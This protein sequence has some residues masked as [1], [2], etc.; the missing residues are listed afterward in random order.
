MHLISSATSSRPS[1]RTP[2]PITATLLALLM[3]GLLTAGCGQPV[4]KTALGPA[5][6]AVTTSDAAGD[7]S[8]ADA[9]GSDA[10]SADAGGGWHVGPDAGVAFTGGGW[11]KVKNE[12]G[13]IF[14]FDSRAVAL[15]LSQTKEPEIGKAYVWWMRTPGH[16]VANFGVLE[17]EEK[18]YNPDISMVQK[19][20]VANS[21]A[22]IANFNGAF[23]TYEDD[24]DLEKL[25]A[26]V[27]PVVW[28]GEIP[29]LA[30]NHVQHVLTVS[31]A[32]AQ[33]PGYIQMAGA[34]MTAVR[35]QLKAAE[36]AIK[37]GKPLVAVMHVENIHTLLVGVAEAKDLTGDKKFKSDLSVYTMG[38]AAGDT[39]LNEALKHAGFALKAAEGSFT[40]GIKDGVDALEA[41]T[42]GFN[43]N[44]TKTLE[45]VVGFANGT[46]KNFKP[47]TENVTT[48]SNK[49]NE[50]LFG[51]RKL[52]EIPMER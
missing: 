10:A 3:C 15:E 39:P 50:A 26:P 5:D 12:T 20:D 34:I 43:A 36:D 24:I 14:D 6:A 16:S 23:V 45:A 29:Q 19:P 22:H 47:V 17:H 46:S 32:A 8:S 44:M 51:A 13:N 18:V 49:F 11:V 37:G 31:N 4:V 42:K 28:K 38:L 7:G 48:L 52:A 27:G 33:Q 1:L 25:K 41:A 2:T 9:G 40:P 21:P 30:W 35:G